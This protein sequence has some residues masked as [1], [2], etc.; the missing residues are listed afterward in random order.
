MKNEKSKNG[1]KDTGILLGVLMVYVCRLF[2]TAC[3]RSVQTKDPERDLKISN[4][5]LR[6]IS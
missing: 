2:L 5:A 1:K 6:A 3:D 4:Q